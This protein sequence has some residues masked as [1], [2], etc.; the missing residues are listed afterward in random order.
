MKLRLL[1][2]DFI[3][4]NWRFQPG[5]DCPNVSVEE[6]LHRAS[7]PGPSSRSSFGLPISYLTSSG[8]CGASLSC[9]P[10]ELLLPRMPSMT[11]RRTCAHR[12]SLC[13]FFFP[14]LKSGFKSFKFAFLEEVSKVA[15]ENK[16]RR[17]KTFTKVGNSGTLGRNRTMLSVEE[18]REQSNQISE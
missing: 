13:F 7:L 14:R 6:H 15:R 9:F 4:E 3:N 11:I 18:Q 12:N 17:K 16:E 8:N 10:R 5:S 1:Q 2:K